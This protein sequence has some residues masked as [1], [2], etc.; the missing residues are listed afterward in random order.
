AAAP[1]PPR[2]GRRGAK[3]QPPLA[4]AAGRRRPRSARA[5][6]L[7]DLDRRGSRDLRRLLLARNGARH[8]AGRARVRGAPPR[9]SRGV[10]AVSLVAGGREEYRARRFAVRAR[11]P[12]REGVVSAAGVPIAWEEYG[13]GEH[14]VLFIPP[15]QIVHSR[16][17]KAQLPYFAR[18]FRVVTYDP[19]GNGRSGRPPSGYD[20]DRAAADVLTVLDATAT[21][22]ASLV[23]FSR[24]T[25]PGVILAARHPER[26]ERLVIAGSALAEGPPPGFHEPRDRY[27]GRQKYNAHYW[28]THYR[29]FVE[30]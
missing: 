2:R 10:R 11:R 15:W 12:D 28:T 20:H 7:H 3:D 18:H 27:N 23:C 4:G 25:W 6:R 16:V 21:P 19:P 5:L 1:T 17:W 9:E 30:F 29:E 26:V 13:A 24:S 22:R 8:H 14:T